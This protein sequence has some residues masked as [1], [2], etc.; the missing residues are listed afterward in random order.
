M[1]ACLVTYRPLFSSASLELSKISSLFNRSR[2]SSGSRKA[3]SPDSD[4]AEL[5]WEG[6]ENFDLRIPKLS[7]RATDTGLHI[8]NMNLRDPKVASTENQKNNLRATKVKCKDLPTI[9]DI[10]K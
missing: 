5:Q 9:A 3:L 6:K 4:L 10:D 1:G 2:S 7:A 8:I